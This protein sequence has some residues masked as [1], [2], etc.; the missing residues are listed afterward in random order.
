MTDTPTGPLTLAHIEAHQDAKG[1]RKYPTPLAD[2]GLSVGALLL[3]GLEEAVDLRRYLMLAGVWTLGDEDWHA[4]LVDRLLPIAD[5]PAPLPPDVPTVEA[6]REYGEWWQYAHRVVEK[7][8]RRGYGSAQKQTSHS[9]AHARNKSRTLR[10][11]DYRI[12]KGRRRKRRRFLRLHP[13]CL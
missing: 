8:R 1:A 6:V 2:A 13:Q 4:D 5:H 9:A 12:H 3:H 7:G 10:Q 11:G